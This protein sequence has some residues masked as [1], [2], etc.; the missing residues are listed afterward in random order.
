MHHVY[1]W[2]KALHRWQVD[3]KYLT[4][5]PNY[6]KLG[7]FDIYLFEITFR[8]FKTGATMVFFWDDR[9]KTS[10]FTAFE[11]FEKIM[12]NVWVNLKEIVFQ[13]DGGAEFSNI[14]ICWTK[15]KLIEMIEEKFWDFRI[16]DK[17]EQNWHVEAFHRRI[18]DD[19]FDTK[20]ISDLKLKVD[21]WEITKEQLKSEILKLLNGYVLNFNKYW[22]SSYL[23]R[24][25]CF[26]K[27]SPL[28]ITKE[29]WKDE[30]KA[31]NIDLKYLEKYCGAYDVSTAYNMIRKQDFACVVNSVIGLNEN[32]FDL[33]IKSVKMI[34]N[35]YLSQ[36]YDFVDDSTGQI[37]AGRYKNFQFS[38]YIKNNLKL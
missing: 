5:I 1:A 17:K 21:A 16:I 23:P 19:L 15:W 38:I 36:F 28:A 34:N 27:K 7:V 35:N 30:I 2:Y 37:W 14:K 4:D 24:L 18:E 3:I 22:Y 33:A 6:I 8:D 29:D 13:F 9:S 25:E 26:W 12:V 10:V 20:F 32:N 11:I 31:W